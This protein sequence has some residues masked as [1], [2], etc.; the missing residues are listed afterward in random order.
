MS[1]KVH[2]SDCPWYKD[3]HECNCGMFDEPGFKCTPLIQTQLQDLIARYYA[4]DWENDPDGGA[5]S[6]IVEAYRL[7]RN[8]LTDAMAASCLDWHFEIAELMHKNDNLAKMLENA[9]N[10]NRRLRAQFFDD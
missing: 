1:D 2:A 6:A 10:N 8:E 9:E 7:G 4:G 3:W 5:A